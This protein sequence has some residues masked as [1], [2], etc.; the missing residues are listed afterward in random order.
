META[1][2]AGSLWRRDSAFDRSRVCLRTA[3]LIAIE[4]AFDKYKNAVAAAKRPSRMRAHAINR[5]APSTT[6]E[7]AVRAYDDTRTQT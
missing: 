2:A 6:T 1:R 4:S 3:L 5:N 7:R